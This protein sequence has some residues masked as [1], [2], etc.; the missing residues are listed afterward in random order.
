MARVGT[1]PR[2]GR[3]RSASNSATHLTR[4]ETRTKESN[5]RASQRVSTSP[6][7]AMKVKAGARRPGRDPPSPEGAHH[8]PVS[9]GLPGRWSES[10]RDDRGSQLMRCGQPLDQTSLVVRVQPETPRVQGNLSRP[11]GGPRQVLPANEAQEGSSGVV[12]LLPL[13]DFTCTL[14]GV[15]ANTWT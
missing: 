12:I 11:S 1:G 8:W 6:H 5:G 10:G 3:S 4:L 2:N 7:G 13:Q 14:C 15:S 9:P